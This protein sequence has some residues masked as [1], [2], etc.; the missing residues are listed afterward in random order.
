MMRM[1]PQDHPFQRAQPDEIS[2]YRRRSRYTLG[3]P[4]SFSRIAPNF[5]L[6]SAATPAQDE[7]DTGIS[8]T[9]AAGIESELNSLLTIDDPDPSLIM[10]ADPVMN[11]EPAATF[12]MQD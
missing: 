10:V 7:P 6:S 5:T 9:E 1:K 2:K 3:K 8:Q 11:P 12:S 4:K